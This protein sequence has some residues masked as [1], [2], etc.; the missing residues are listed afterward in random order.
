[1]G[2]F[3]DTYRLLSES[4]C[5]LIAFGI[6]RYPWRHNCL[7]RTRRSRFVLETSPFRPTTRVVHI[8]FAI[9]SDN[10]LCPAIIRSLSAVAP[11]ERSH[12]ETTTGDTACPS[13]QEAC[14]FWQYRSNGR[15]TTRDVVVRTRTRSTTMTDDK[16]VCRPDAHD[17]V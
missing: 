4:E 14:S 15:L 7:H 5:L 3:T 6:Y 12:V 11:A 16:G 8:F 2:S 13:R 10:I 9:R 17:R 1:M